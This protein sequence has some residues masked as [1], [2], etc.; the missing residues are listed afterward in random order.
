MQ[1][2]EPC[3]FKIWKGRRLCDFIGNDALL[4]LVSSRVVELWKTSCFTGFTTYP[5]IVLDRKGQVLS[6]DYYVI[7]ITGRAGT[8]DRANMKIEPNGI[9]I[10]GASPDMLRFHPEQ[11]DGSDFFMLEDVDFTL[12]MRRVIDVMKLNKITGWTTMPIMGLHPYTYY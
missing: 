12:V 3:L 4:L 9:I 11:W 7:G 8:L 2:S 10:P 1:L 5:A 6:G